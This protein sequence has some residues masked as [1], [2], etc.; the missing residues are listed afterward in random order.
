[1]MHSLEHIVHSVVLGAILYFGMVN[2]LQQDKE[3]AL[4]RSTLIAA[5]FLAYMV[6]YGHNLPTNINKNIF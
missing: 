5:V 1:M 6:L 3:V 2:G 4:D